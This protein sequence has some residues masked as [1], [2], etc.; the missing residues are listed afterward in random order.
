MTNLIRVS[1]PAQG[2]ASDHPET[3]DEFITE[4]PTGTL[5]FERYDNDDQY[6]G[7]AVIGEWTRYEDGSAETVLVDEHGEE[8]PLYR[9]QTPPQ[10]IE[11]T[12]TPLS[13]ID[14]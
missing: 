10:P 12:V 7:D 1:G 13:L 14:E 6:L 2:Y 8:L 11:L 5:W 4:F 3:V 9:N